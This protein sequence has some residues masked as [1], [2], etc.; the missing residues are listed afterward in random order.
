MIAIA[1][2]LGLWVGAGLTTW[3]IVAAW[4]SWRSLT[5]YDAL[6][7]VV[8]LLAG[9]LFAVVMSEAIGV[10]LTKRWKSKGAQ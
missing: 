10:A 9:P 1:F 5:S 2:A 6:V 4:G 3:F 8:A 7:L